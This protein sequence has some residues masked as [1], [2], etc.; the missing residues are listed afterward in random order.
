MS[1]KSQMH[2]YGE[3]S[4]GI[5]PAKRSNEGLGRSKEIVE[6]RPLAKEIQRQG[7]SWTQGQRNQVHYTASGTPRWKFIV[8]S[9]SKVGTV[10]VRS[11]STV[12]SGGWWVTT[13][14]TGTRLEPSSV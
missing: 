2:G 6:G 9:L 7:M 4:G 11:A 13:I 12:L 8:A 5:V 3:S 10:C 1:Y 14:P